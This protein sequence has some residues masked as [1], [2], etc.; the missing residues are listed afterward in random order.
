M[1]Q[2]TIG[3]WVAQTAREQPELAR[4]TCVLSTRA[5]PD[6]DE[7]GAN[8]DAAGVVGWADGSVV[9]A[10]AD[11]LGG[12]GDGDVAAALTID[13]ILQAVTATGGD[14]ASIAGAVVAALE[15]ANGAL[16]ERR[17]G[18]ATTIIVAA[19]HGDRLRCFHAG[20]SELLAVGQRGRIRCHTI[21]HSPVSYG[22]EA[23]LID[24]EAGF[25]HDE[26]HL[27]LNYIGREALRIEMSTALTLST[28]DTVLLASDGL[29]DNVPMPEVA[30]I[31]RSGDLNEAVATLEELAGRRM[32]AGMSGGVGKPDDLTVLAYR[33]GPADEGAAG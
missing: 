19:I 21:S 33:P 1:S 28:L 30:E 32:Q 20:D 5:S 12:H 23:G 27:V 17:G 22:V 11:G 14:E 18:M 24:P 7:P 2:S 9:L 3:R 8:E 15:Q 16:L 10:V 13:A 4:G 29:W 6:R 26:R 31:I 25:V